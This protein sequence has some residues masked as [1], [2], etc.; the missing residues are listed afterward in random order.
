MLQTRVS[1]TLVISIKSLITLKIFGATFGI[2]GQLPHWPPWLRSW[3][4]TTCPLPAGMY[5]VGRPVDTPF[6]VRNSRSSRFMK[7]TPL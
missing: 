2:G 3:Y 4:F 5:G 6:E 1:N 7:E